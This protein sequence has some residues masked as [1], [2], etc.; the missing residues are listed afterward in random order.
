MDIPVL[1]DP[2]P[3]GAS[4]KRSF[5]RPP[6]P[7]LKGDP[8]VSPGRHVFIALGGGGS[9]ALANALTR[10]AK[11]VGVRP[12]LHFPPAWFPQLLTSGAQAFDDHVAM[13][14]RPG[15]Y[16]Q[17]GWELTSGYRLD[18]KHPVEKNLKTWIRWLQQ[19][20]SAAV[21]W[22]LAAH[23]FLSR[24]NVRR[25]V[26]LI[27]HPLDAYASFSSPDRHGDLFR[28]LG[29][30]DSK[31]AIGLYAKWWRLTVQEALLLRRKNCDPLLLR[32]ES[33]D[34]DLEK[35]DPLLRGALSGWEARRRGGQA[36]PPATVSKLRALTEDLVHEIYGRWT[37]ETDD[38]R[39]PR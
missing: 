17:E 16:L 14:S 13:K 15:P 21:V 7:A 19:T 23:G 11:L 25:P 1:R 33:M 9:T 4:E 10:Y 27:R 30:L 38:E 6:T 8:E 26:F 39:R 5:M 34:E 3:V 20:D 22:L 35:A 2:W 29:G 36:L 32:Y 37:L 31:R 28:S 24:A 18:L 12:D